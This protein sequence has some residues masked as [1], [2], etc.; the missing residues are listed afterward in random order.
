MHQTWLIYDLC[1]KK[2]CVHLVRNF[3]VYPLVTVEVCLHECVS[4]CI[5]QSSNGMAYQKMGNTVTG[6]DHVCVYILTSMCLTVQEPHDQDV[7]MT[8]RLVD[9]QDVSDKCLCM[10]ACMYVCI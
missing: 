10:Y 1:Y 7:T 4:V 9:T 6:Q 8:P 3:R 5:P 2:L